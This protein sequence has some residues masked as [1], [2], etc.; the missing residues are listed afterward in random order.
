MEQLTIVEKKG[1]NYT[2]L[3]L[4][5]SCNAYT[6]NEFQQKIYSYIKEVNLVLDLSKVL[7]MD[8]TA[9]GILLAGFNDSLDYGHKIYLMNMSPSAQ[10]AMADTGFMEAFNVIQSVTEVVS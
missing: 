7:D 2:L 6:I 3:E 4:A 5:G 10:K 8:S 9:V 1:A